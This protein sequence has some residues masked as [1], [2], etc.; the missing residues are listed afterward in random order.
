[1]FVSKFIKL[2]DEFNFSFLLFVLFTLNENP[3]TVN[4]NS[5][6]YFS[7]KG[8]S[9]SCVLYSEIF[10]FGALYSY[11]FLPIALNLEN[12]GSIV[13]SPINIKSLRKFV[14]LLSWKNLGT[15]SLWILSLNIL[16]LIFE[17]FKMIVNGLKNRI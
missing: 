6:I 16:I 12:C 14:C 17:S 4:V 5:S 13:F 11:N 8:K 3:L 2:L 7:G 1:M 10:W 9:I 15:Y